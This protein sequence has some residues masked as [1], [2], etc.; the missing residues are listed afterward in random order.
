MALFDIVT[1]RQVEMGKIKIGG[2]EEK[3]RTSQSGNKW[4]APLKYDHFVV[5]TLHRTAGRC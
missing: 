1:P 5:T 4:R 2:L 3:V